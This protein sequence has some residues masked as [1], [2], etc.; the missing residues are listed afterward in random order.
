MEQTAE[1]MYNAGSFS[2]EEL[3]QLVDTLQQE[4]QY[5]DLIDGE[6]LEKLFFLICSETDTFANP[7]YE[8]LAE[9]DFDEDP[10]DDSMSAAVFISTDLL[11]T[12]EDM[13][14]FI[15]DEYHRDFVQYAFRPLWG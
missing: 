1:N 5:Q 8:T 4:Q 3:E 11:I 9:T 15:P 6:L 13:F 2:L 10:A 14:D 12:D 7:I